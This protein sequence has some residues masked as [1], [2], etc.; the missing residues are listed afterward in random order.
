[1]SSDGSDEF[2]EL[3]KHHFEDD[4][5]FVKIKTINKK[6]IF[7]NVY[8]KLSP[9]DISNDFN[10][11]EPYEVCLNVILSYVDKKIFIEYLNQCGI[12]NGGSIFL[13]KIK[14]FASNYGFKSIELDDASE[15][16]VYFLENGEIKREINISLMNYKIL[17]EGK[18]W[19]GKHGYENEYYL[20]H[21]SEINEYIH[22]SIGEVLKNH[23]NKIKEVQKV[24]QKLVRLDS[25]K[26]HRV[27]KISKYLNIREFQI[28]HWN[29]NNIYNQYVDELKKSLSRFGIGDDIENISISELMDIF[30]NY[31]KI[32]CKDNK[33]EEQSFDDV[34]II[35]DNIEDFYNLLL[36]DL[37]LNE[38]K[39]QT[40]KLYI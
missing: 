1:M 30:Y 39:L 12:R 5:F 9:T 13:N 15:F 34:I 25:I 27:D 23:I 28:D 11:G 19:Y 32:K 37:D 17:K 26:F 10:D 8:N 40:W 6:D 24:I 35:K 22:K 3:I 33:C 7:F 21:K 18:T 29:K 2:V 4:P 16:Y 38:S 31:F 36:F 20:S 14:L